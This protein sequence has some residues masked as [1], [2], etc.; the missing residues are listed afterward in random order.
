[1]ADPNPSRPVLLAYDGSDTAARAI[2]H[3]G[4]ALG[5]GP[6]VALTAFEPT[7]SVTGYDPLAGVSE[8][9]SHATGLEREMDEIG[10]QVAG[11]TAE[12]GAEVARR[13]GFDATARTAEGKVWRAIVD[14]AD[15]IDAKVIVVGTRG[16]GGL[17]SLMIGSVAN[18]VV[19]HSNRPVLVIPPAS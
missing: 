6:A 8:G 1:M 10:A 3:A 4:A 16:H 9:M 13:H 7:A 2:E 17:Q 14:T 18:G 5:G 11:R 12:Q 15:E 19:H